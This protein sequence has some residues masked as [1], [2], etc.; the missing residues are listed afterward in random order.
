MALPSG[1]VVTT[2][3]E[4]GRGKGG[5]GLPAVLKAQVHAGAIVTGKASDAT[6]E[7]RALAEA[8]AR[9]IENLDELAPA[10]RAALLRNHSSP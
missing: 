6:E 10:V 3:E 2:P 4:A 9:V 5:S 8:G 7:K 1:V